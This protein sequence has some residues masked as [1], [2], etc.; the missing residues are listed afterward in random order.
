MSE[1]LYLYQAVTSAKFFSILRHKSCKNMFL[2]SHLDFFDKLQ[3]IP[4]FC[5]KFKTNIYRGILLFTPTI[6]TVN[7]I[8]LSTL[9]LHD[10]IITI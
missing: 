3:T 5:Y 6:V 9:N 4:V 1:L 2:E 10:L 8:D 7:D